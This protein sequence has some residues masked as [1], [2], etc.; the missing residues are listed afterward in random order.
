MSATKTVSSNDM[1]SIAYRIGYLSKSRIEREARKTEPRLWKL[2]GHASLFDNAKKYIID[3]IDDDDD[4][5]EAV[6]DEWAESDDELSTIDHIEDL[7][8]LEDDDNEPAPIQPPPHPQLQRQYQFQYYQACTKCISRP[9]QKP[10]Q[11]V[12]TTVIDCASESE[13][14]SEPEDQHQHHQRGFED[15]ENVSDVSTEGDEGDHDHDNTSDSDW[16]ESTCANEDHVYDASP[17][18]KLI[19]LCA[20]AT[21]QFSMPKYTPQDEDMLLWAQQPR[22]LSQTQADNLLVEAFA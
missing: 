3:H 11:V 6:V 12:V 8:D 10:Q 16:S 5:D 19:D 21:S 18:R 22:V 17:E 2:I 1:R 7:L 9:D 20:L 13:S 15:W 14:E 4:D